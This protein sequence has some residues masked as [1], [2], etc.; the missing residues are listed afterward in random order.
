[1]S[2]APPD[3]PPAR[4]PLGPQFFAQTR[5]DKVGNARQARTALSVGKVRLNFT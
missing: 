2:I 5:D 3:P 1:M 4:G